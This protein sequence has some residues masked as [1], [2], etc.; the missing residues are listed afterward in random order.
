MKV[1]PLKS[2]RNLVSTLLLLGATPLLAEAWLHFDARPGSKVKIE[3]ASTMGDWTV[4]GQI[5]S[6]FFEIEPGFQTDATLQSVPSLTTGNASPIVK[7]SILVRS[8]KSGK[9]LMDQIMQDAMKEKEFRKI[10]YALTEMKLKEAPPTAGSPYK[11]DT[12]GDLAVSGVTNKI[13]MEVSMERVDKDRLKFVGSIQLKMTDF[14]IKPPAPSVGSG[15]IKTADEVQVSFEW[16]T[17]LRTE[18]K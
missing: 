14:G 6:G 2:T 17:G 3:G 1:L 12:K 18:A 9:T 16:L 8:L 13:S 15:P 4:E 5:I 7:V 10:E 11:F